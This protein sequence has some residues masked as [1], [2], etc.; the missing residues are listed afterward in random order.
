MARRGFSLVELLVVIAILAVLLGVLLPGLAAARRTARSV[1]CLANVRSLQIASAMYAD[2]HRGFLID[3]GLAHGGAGDESLSWVQ[4]LREFYDTPI[5]TRSPGD[6]SPYW[7]AAQGGQGLTIAGR[8]RRTSYGMNNFLSRTYNPGI[9]P[10]EPFDTLA[11]IDSPAATVQ[12]LLMTEQGDFAVSDHTH[13]ENWGSGHRAAAV[14][15]TQIKVHAWGGSPSRADALSNWGFVDA[16]AST[17]RFS[18][19]YV[20]WNHNRFNPET[21][22]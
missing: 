4:T 5:V 14:A 18:S 9:L 13:V 21:A 17:L 15:S 11:K 1:K 12:F 22:R 2:A 7:P 10:R 16:H 3:V 6:T 8:P 19:V 20:D